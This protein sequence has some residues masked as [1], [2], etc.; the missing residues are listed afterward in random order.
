MNDGSVSQ[1]LARAGLDWIVPRWSAPSSV[2]ALSTTR[3]AGAARGIDLAPASPA[4]DEA[5]AY[6]RRFV[7][8]EPLWLAQQHGTR[9]VDA[10]QMHAQS[11]V[12]DAAVA[13]VA[14]KVCAVLSGDCLPV[15]FAARDGRVVAAAHAGWRGLAAGVLEAT[16]ASMNIAPDEVVAWMGP[17]IGAS[18]FEVGDEVRAG[19]CDLDSAA[20]TAFIAG[21]PGKWFADLHALARR[22][23]ARAGVL[24]VSGLA[25]C[26]FTESASFYSYRRGGADAA[27]R[28]ATLIW[29]DTT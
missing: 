29:R 19:F 8:A 1:H 24:E 3:N 2:H 25:R 11:P 10:D 26:T 5:R 17:S 18:A 23:L 20:A 13:R 7:P 14:G 12:A 21:Q 22:R 9:V 16:L 27:G 4:I 15:L 6:L 28:M